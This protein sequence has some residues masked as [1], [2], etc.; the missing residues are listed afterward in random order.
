V[1]SLK[2]HNSILKGNLM[3]H[4]SSFKTVHWFDSSETLAN[5]TIAFLKA[6]EDTASPET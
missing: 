1:R 6:Q 4:I 2:R 5:Q 3:P